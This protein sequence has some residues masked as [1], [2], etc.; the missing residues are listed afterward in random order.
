MKPIKLTY[1]AKENNNLAGV[2]TSIFS[3]AF[4][5]SGTIVFIRRKDRMRRHFSEDVKNIPCPSL[6]SNHILCPYGVIMQ[7]NMHNIE[8]NGSSEKESAIQK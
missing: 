1:S 2:Q 4:N 3:S 5:M 6:A 8:R 7:N